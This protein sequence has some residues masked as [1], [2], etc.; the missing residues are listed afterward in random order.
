MLI[1]PDSDKVLIEQSRGIHS[2]LGLFRDL[3]YSFGSVR[4]D[5]PEWALARLP[6]NC[7]V[8]GCANITSFPL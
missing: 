3:G 1:Q 5:V 8:I 2:A 4:D 7:T 6:R